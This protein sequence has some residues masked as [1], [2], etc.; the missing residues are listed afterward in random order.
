MA[1]FRDSKSGVAY[2]HSTIAIAIHSY[3]CNTSLAS[4]WDAHW[5]RSMRLILFIIS[6]APRKD[7]NV[8]EHHDFRSGFPQLLSFLLCHT[9]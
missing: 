4:L 5:V 7:S 9:W 1:G 6:S 3:S 8:C 2:L